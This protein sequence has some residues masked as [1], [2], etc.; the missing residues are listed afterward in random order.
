MTKIP[1]R[2][3]DLGEGGGSFWPPPWATTYTEKDWATAGSKYKSQNNSAYWSVQP[4]YKTADRT[5]IYIYVYM[6]V[7]VCV[8]CCEGVVGRS[9]QWRPSLRLAAELIWYYYNSFNSSVCVCVVVGGLSP[10]RLSVDTRHVVV[11]KVSPHELLNK[12]DNDCCSWPQVYKRGWSSQPIGEAWVV[13][14]AERLRYRFVWIVN[15]AAHEVVWTPKN[16]SPTPSTVGPLT[17]TIRPQHKHIA[18]LFIYRKL[19][20]AIANVF[21]SSMFY[22]LY[23]AFATNKDYW[24]R[25]RTT[26]CCI[27]HIISFIYLLT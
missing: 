16:V 27:Q 8:A 9:H 25:I 18:N 6:C 5:Y 11:N 12:L 17:T 26:S 10:T 24:F 14:S 7:C 13:A 23:S 21:C 22:Y 15:W 20:L 4:S 2:S 19:T 3:R 1:I